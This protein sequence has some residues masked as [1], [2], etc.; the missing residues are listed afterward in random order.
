MLIRDIGFNLCRIPISRKKQY[1]KQEQSITAT[2]GYLV[3][4]GHLLSPKS[5]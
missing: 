3:T 2:T 5:N 4:R 1:M